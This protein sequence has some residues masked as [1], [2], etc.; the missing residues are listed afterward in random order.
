MYVYVCVHV[1]VCSRV[2][3]V[4]CVCEV[5]KKAA[6]SVCCD[7]LWFCAAVVLNSLVLTRS[8]SISICLYRVLFC[9]RGFG[10]G[11]ACRFVVSSSS[12][13]SFFFLLLLLLLLRLLALSLSLSLT[14]TLT[15]WIVCMCFPDMVTVKVFRPQTN[16]HILGCTT[17]IT[18]LLK[19]C[20]VCTL[21][22]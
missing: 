12:S 6:W 3:V 18:L 7:W 21:G 22:R 17:L 1:F 9:R 2:Y 20:F 15:L 14:H 5:K 11:N 8:H 19:W 13:S 4:L 16:T 10:R